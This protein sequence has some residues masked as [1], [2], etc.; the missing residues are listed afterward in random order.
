[1]LQARSLA[2]K[3]FPL[4]NLAGNDY[5]RHQIV[6]WIGSFRDEF[7]TGMLALHTTGGTLCICWSLDG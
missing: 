1:M 5:Q 4:A 3:L 6:R 7:P 2:R